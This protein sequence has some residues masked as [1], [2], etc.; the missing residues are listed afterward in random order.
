LPPRGYMPAGS[1]NLKK[2]LG[3]PRI[4]VLLALASQNR[5]R[6]LGQVLNRQIIDLGPL[7]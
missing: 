1:Q 6:Q 2:I 5:H 4:R 3:I 7:H